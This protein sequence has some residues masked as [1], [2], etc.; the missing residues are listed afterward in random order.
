MKN[1]QKSGIFFEIVRERMLQ[2]YQNYYLDDTD[3]VLESELER[4]LNAKTE[5]TIEQTMKALEKMTMKQFA[6]KVVNY[7]KNVQLEWVIVGNFDET[8]LL[9]T[10]KEFEKTLTNNVEVILEEPCMKIT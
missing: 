9:E 10:I 6:E 3:D 8:Q 5:S 1:K 2:E 7:W 4:M